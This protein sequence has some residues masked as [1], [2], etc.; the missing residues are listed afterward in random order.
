MPEDDLAAKIA[1]YRE[2]AAT[3]REN[4]EQ[5]RFDLRRGNQLRA[6]ADGFERSAAR[7]EDQSNSLQSVSAVR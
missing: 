6:L 3:L 4:A 5:L 7:L 2:V 1:R